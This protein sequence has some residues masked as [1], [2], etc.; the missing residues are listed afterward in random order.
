MQREH[1]KVYFQP[2]L[3]K[4]SLLD[5]SNLTLKSIAKMTNAILAMQKNI[6]KIYRYIDICQFNGEKSIEKSI[7][8][9]RKLILRVRKGVFKIYLQ[10]EFLHFSG[11]FK[12]QITDHQNNI[13]Q[14]NDA[15]NSTK[16]YHQ[17]NKNYYND[18]CE[19]RCL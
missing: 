1:A 2:L 6:A 9:S 3:E 15:K 16:K 12:K 5:I 10:N 8:R 7:T 17:D 14:F 4:K 19:A 13:S 11:S 18:T